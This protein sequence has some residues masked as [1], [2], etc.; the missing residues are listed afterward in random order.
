MSVKLLYLN[1]PMTIEAQPTDQSVRG[2]RVRTGAVW[3][4]IERACLTE[5]FRPKPSALCNW[6]HFR[7]WCPVYGGDPSAAVEIAE[8][9]RNA[10]SA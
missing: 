2:L 6:C 3:S 7:P 1:E 9:S 10:L 8:A 4:A 5:D